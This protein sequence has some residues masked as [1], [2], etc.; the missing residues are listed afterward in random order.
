EVERAF[1]HG[2][3]GHRYVAVPGHE[4]DRQR[5]AGAEQAL[6]ELEAAEPGH[7]D[8]EHETARPLRVE[9]GEELLARREH[10]AGEPHGFEQELHGAQ[11]AAIVIDDEDRRRLPGV[12]AHAANSGRGPEEVQNLIPRSPG[13]INQ[14]AGAAYR[15]R[16]SP[17]RAGKPAGRYVHMRMETRRPARHSARRHRDKPTQAETKKLA[18]RTIAPESS[19]RGGG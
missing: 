16:A 15:I 7:A 14:G 8:V 10:L 13:T 2:F 19:V 17:G 4:D 11:D 12:A 3:D 9:A 18:R 1:L 6:L 5:A